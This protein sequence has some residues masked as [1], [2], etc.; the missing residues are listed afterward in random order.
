MLFH[1]AV[2]IQGSHITWKQVG[3]LHGHLHKITFA[4]LGIPFGEHLLEYDI[5]A[6]L[7]C[8]NQATRLAS[9]VTIRPYS[10]LAG[11]AMEYTINQ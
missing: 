10:K 1:Y 9:A 8:Y 3:L 5:I 7:L 4:E 11:N 6:Y 2:Q